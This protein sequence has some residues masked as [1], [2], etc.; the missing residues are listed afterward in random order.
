MPLHI[1]GKHAQKYMSPNT[2]F[3]AMANGRTMRSTVLKDPKR[4]FSLAE[5]LI[6][7]H[8]LVR[9]HSLFRQAGSYDI[10]SIE[11]GLF[12]NLVFIDFKAEIVVA[13]IEFEMLPNLVLI[14]NL[15]DP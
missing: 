8:R 10:D 14:D 11:C 6:T 4:S 1:V 3:E 5:Q 7:A 15:A 9:I 13:N 12:F 2:V